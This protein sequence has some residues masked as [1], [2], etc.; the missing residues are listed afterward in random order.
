MSESFILQIG[1]YKSSIRL[2]EP[3]IISLG[4]LEAAEN[5]IVVIEDN[6]GRK[7]FGECS[8]FPTIH[9][10]T[11]ETCFSV[12][13]ELSKLLIGKNPT[14]IDECSNLLDRYIFANTS[15]KSAINI[16]LYDLA[17]Q[18]A[19]LPLFK[20]LGAVEYKKLYTDYTVSLDS[21][22]KMTADAEKI[23]NAG[24]PVIK[25][26]LG[27]TKEKDVS[28]IKAIREKVG[29]EIPI[30]IDA[31]QGWNISN[32]LEILQA[33]AP[34]NIQHCEEPFSRK[35]YSNLPSLKEKSPIPIMADESCFDHHDAEKLVSIDAC[36]AFNVKLGKSSGIT[37]ALKII[38]IAERENK[39]LQIGGFLESRLGFTAAAH[40]ALCCKSTPC[41]DFDTPLMFAEDV[42]QEGIRYSEGGLITIPE[43]IGLGA[44]YTETFLRSLLGFVVD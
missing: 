9:G 43:T 3:F 32:A 23:L 19:G 4:K 1:I 26:K 29:M 5:I 42:V 8:P 11:M 12:G 27:G 44:Y 18:D 40:V 33:L 13:I 20:F 39:P 41:I 36:D 37:N 15:I 16:A 25:V 24:F 31:N 17:A 6:N 38:A 30:R 21:V 34:Y 28:R 14:A 10:E 35:D 22:E 7:G 2:K